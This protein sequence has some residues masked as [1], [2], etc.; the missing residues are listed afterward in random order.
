MIIARTPFRVSFCGGGSDLK[1]Y[2]KFGMGAVLS[3]TINKYIYVALNSNPDNFFRISHSTTENA[4]K[5]D[6]IK[7]SLIREAVK[8]ANIG[9]SMQISI[10][11]DV[12]EGTGLGS[13]SSLA[14]GL[15]NALHS[16]KNEAVTKNQLAEK[17]CELEIEILKEP[18]G[19]Q[20]Q[21]AAAFGGLN[22]ITFHK[23]ERVEV[24]PIKLKDSVKKELEDNLLM[25]YTGITR[26]ASSILKEQ[27][28]STLKD[29]KKREILDKMRDQTFELKKHLENG[30]IDML[31]EMLRQ[32]WEY[33]KCM[34]GRITNPVIE[35]Y[36]QRALNAGAAGGK[37]LGAG[38][39]GFLLFYV[40]KEKQGNVRKALSGLKEMPFKFES[41]GTKVIY[42]D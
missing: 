12:P 19:K 5:V 20:D 9:R 35:N 33:K 25:F 13:S 40:K 3:T 16:Y 27:K 21:Y 7:H 10:I 32:A 1:A 30:D 34:A 31:G 18:I 37:I 29:R 41:E 14:V 39:G 38:G 15:L 8:M 42:R 28:E 24:E 4:R 26:K 6:E 2:Y 17:A 11:S 22:L 23:D 36:Y